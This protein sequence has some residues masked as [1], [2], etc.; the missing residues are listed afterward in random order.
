MSSTI[1]KNYSTTEEVAK[2]LRFF[3]EPKT[4]AHSDS[5]T[6]HTESHKSEEA[7]HQHKAEAHN[8]EAHLVHGESLDND[9]NEGNATWKSRISKVLVA[10][11][12]YALV[13]IVGV[14]GYVFFLS[15]SNFDLSVIKQVAPKASVAP[16]TIKD[17]EILALQ[18]NSEVLNQ[19][20]KWINNYY[21][22][23]S[24]I[25]ILDP[26]SDNSGNGLSN[27][28]KYLM[29]LS[30]KAYDSIGLG[31][32]DSQ[33]I[34]QGINPL[35]GSR[36]TVKQQEIV[37]KYFDLEIINNR[38]TLEQLNKQGYVAGK[39]ITNQDNSFDVSNNFLTV[40][41]A[42]NGEK[43]TQR[44]ISAQP[45]GVL[46]AYDNPVV[47]EIDANNIN[48]ETA[49]RLEIPSLGINVP[50]IWTKNTKN[51][52]TDL[53][54]GVVHYPGTALPGQ[55]GTTYISGHS[56]NYAWAK[57]EYNKVFSKLGDLPDNS[58]F[59]VTVVQKNGQDARLHY[60]VIKRKEFSPTDQEQFRNTGDSLVALSTCWPIGSTKSRLVVFG[61]LTQ[62]EK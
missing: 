37:D 13:F 23:V 24:D 44:P 6:H 15:N 35:S 46:P 21:F 62:V 14:I 17:S 53:Q 36:L 56:S 27:F 11:I 33:A 38:L 19:Y 47:S 54:K 18:K 3:D 52:E 32:P 41:T 39:S 34:A 25:T 26:N 9:E 2:L 50:V 51:F 61:K 31:M 48:L 12:P 29:G 40:E 57:G 28:H 7:D 58:S 42:R 10:I 8:S 49:G 59:I 16:V 45:Q 43:I 60:V 1:G 30:P 5:H 55:I 22:D 20:Y 4:H